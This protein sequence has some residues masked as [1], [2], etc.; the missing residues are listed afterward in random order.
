MVGLF[1][2]ENAFGVT[3]MSRKQILC[4]CIVVNANGDDQRF[5]N[6]NLK[7]IPN[8]ARM[9]SRGQVSKSH[10][11]VPYVSPDSPGKGSFWIIEVRASGRC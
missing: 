2:W 5:P 10:F 4:Y 1:L 7:K 8:E 6:K 9:S 3:S 11:Y